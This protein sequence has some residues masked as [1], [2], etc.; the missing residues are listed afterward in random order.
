[1]K[2]G[3]A[4]QR[5]LQSLGIGHQDN[6]VITFD[7]K[8]SIPNKPVR[9]SLR[10]PNFLDSEPQPTTP[11][12]G[13]YNPNSPPGSNEDQPLEP[14]TGYAPS[15]VAGASNIEPKPAARFSDYLE[16]I[17][18][19]NQPPIPPQVGM[20]TSVFGGLGV[21]KISATEQGQNPLV[22]W[23]V[24]TSYTGFNDMVGEMSEGG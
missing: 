15:T 10:Y 21:W 16:F 19:A 9:V 14:P 7:V 1:M 8:T 6:A 24:D 4:H 20:N 12:E 11:P 2:I 23:V 3:L 18:S 13:F 17:Q 22:T 5:P